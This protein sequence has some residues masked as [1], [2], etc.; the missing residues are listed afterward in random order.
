MKTTARGVLRLCHIDSDGE[1]FSQMGKS[2]LTK[3]TALAVSRAEQDC[4][5]KALESA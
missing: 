4:P 2:L 5:M 1:G 3:G